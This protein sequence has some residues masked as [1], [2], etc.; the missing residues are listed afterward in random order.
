MEPITRSEQYLASI[1]GE[2]VVLPVPQS[3]IEH[4]LNLIAQNGISPSSAGLISYDP[5][6]D[7]P[8]GSLGAGM[9]AEAAEVADLKSEL[10]DKVDCLSK[11]IETVT[12]D[13]QLAFPNV[14]KNL[15]DQGE[16][17]TDA[18]YSTTDFIDIEDA[19]GIYR[20]GTA[21][22]FYMWRYAFYDADYNF[23][24]LVDLTTNYETE[25]YDGKQVTWLNLNENAKYVRIVWNVPR[26]YTYHIVRNVEAVTSYTLV[27]II[28]NGEN[29][30]N[31]AVDGKD[32]KVV[33]DGIAEAKSTNVLNPEE[34]T[35]KGYYYDF[36]D[37]TTKVNFTA[38]K[39]TDKISVGTATTL[40]IRA[41]AE[42]S[43]VG[44]V[45][46]YYYNGDSYV[47]YNTTRYNDLVNTSVSWEKDAFTHIIVFANN[48][49]IVPSNLC[50]SLKP[51]SEFETYGLK[52]YVKNS[53]IQIPLMQ[54][55]GKVIA[56]FG[57]SIFGNKRPPNDISTALANITGATVY[58]LG[59]GGCRMSQHS[60]NWDAFSM[61]RL[62]DAIATGDFSLQNAVDVDNVSGMPAYF[63]TTRTLLESIDFSE[64]DIITIAYGTNDF[65][66]AVA[67]DNANNPTDTTTFCG[68][69]R[70][71]LE[72]ILTS[73]PQLHIFVCTP[74][75]RFWMDN[76]TFLYDSDT[77]EINDKKLTDFVEAVKT[78]SKAYHVKSI[79]NYYDL[80]INQYNRSHWFP[81]GDGTHHNKDGGV[82]IAQHI[83]TELF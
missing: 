82:L 76:G 39:M 71:S 30:Y 38:G 80:G 6:A 62:A 79:D 16:L 34:M 27:P 44:I 37:G 33:T 73:Y 24:S 51:L 47:G 69:L 14:D 26:P 5:D 28:I 29:I 78:V 46:I 35:Y 32:A 4:Y 57:D 49:G 77:H 31:D 17:T 13:T 56:N 61:Y 81:T 41:M 18:N 8:D 15:S 25:E 48:D 66:A 72:T 22:K 3:R 65:T 59:F 43:N 54:L 74:T 55:E 21:T 63:K 19:V 2:D 9:K 1:I 53:A 75:W 40:S 7:Y 23:L 50:V 60:A 42:T 36:T 58:N 20:T 12:T 10:T 11:T 67:L 64:V 52:Y 70:Y 45:I 83:A 68:A